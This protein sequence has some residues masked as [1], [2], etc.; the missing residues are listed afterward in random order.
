MAAEAAFE[1]LGSAIFGRRRAGAN[2]FKKLR[3]VGKALD[4]PAFVRYTINKKARSLPERAHLL[5]V[6]RRDIMNSGMTLSLVLM[7]A[8]AV[9]I[10]AVAFSRTRLDARSCAARWRWGFLCCPSRSRCC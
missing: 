8:V 3:I 7:Y 1:M 5:M 2:G 6:L 4:K 10:L 9:V